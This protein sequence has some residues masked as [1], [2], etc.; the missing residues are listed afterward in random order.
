MLIIDRQ[1]LYPFHK[2]RQHSSIPVY[3]SSKNAVLISD[4]TCAPQKTT[5]PPRLFIPPSPSAVPTSGTKSVYTASAS[6]PLVPPEVVISSSPVPGAGKRPNI[7]PKQRQPPPVPQGRP[8]VRGPA[9]GDIITE[10]KME[11]GQGGKRLT[12]G[13]GVRTVTAG[14]SGKQSPVQIGVGRGTTVINRDGA[15]EDNLA[16]ASVQRPVE[17]PNDL[18]VRP[19]NKDTVT[20]LANSADSLAPEA[21]MEDVIVK[22]AYKET[23]SI[24]IRWESEIPNNNIL[25]FRVVYR[26]FGQ[27]QFKVGP[28]LAPSEREFKI[29]NVPDNVSILVAI[30]CVSVCHSVSVVSVTNV[31]TQCHGSHLRVTC[32]DRVVTVDILML[33]LRDI[34]S[35]LSCHHYWV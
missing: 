3:I 28:P 22:E 21:L 33:R 20:S 23:N 10:L 19:P 1:H 34:V 14:L 7:V 6:R 27:P 29:K 5:Q 2:S 16:S 25:G 8:P 18:V 9:P 32:H 12:S 17:R 26:L 11:V 30:I 15:L 13:T 24:V 4:L 31:V 35:S